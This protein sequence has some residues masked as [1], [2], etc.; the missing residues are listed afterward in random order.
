MKVKYISDDGHEFESKSACE[1]YEEALHD[2]HEISQLTLAEVNGKRWYRITSVAEF[3]YFDHLDDDEQR[4]S[5]NT[6][7]DIAQLVSKINHYFPFWVSNDFGHT[8]I[9][10]KRIEAIDL[11]I[12]QLEKEI[13][14]LKGEKKNLEDLRSID[15]NQLQT[16]SNEQI[17]RDQQKIKEGAKPTGQSPTRPSKEPRMISESGKEKQPKNNIRQ[18]FSDPIVVGEREYPLVEIVATAKSNSGLNDRQWNQLSQEERD[19]FIEQEI[20]FLQLN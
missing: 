7:Y 14:N 10:K 1:K 20:G 3:Y 6:L 18:K 4:H 2:I 16:V 5:A 19:A 9:D 13:Q 8:M 15:K 11:T 12:D 17:V